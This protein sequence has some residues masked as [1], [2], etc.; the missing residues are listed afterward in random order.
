ME[1]EPKEKPKEDPKVRLGSISFPDNP[2]IITPPLPFPQRFQKK[3]LDNQ[4]SKFL[5][6]FKKIHI[7][8]SFV[9]ALEKMSNYAK[10]TKEVMS[11]KRR[12]E[13]MRR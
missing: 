2:P 1:E 9:D 12:L 4:F 3:E 7:N 6:I 11:K 10:F 5:E 13:D 8:I